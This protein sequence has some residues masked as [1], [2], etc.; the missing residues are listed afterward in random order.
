MADWGQIAGGVGGA[1]LGGLA[2]GPLGAVGGGMLGASLFGK[3]KKTESRPDYP[4]M[5]AENLYKWATDYQKQYPYDPAKPYSGKLSAEMTPIEN[6]SQE[7]LSNYMDMGTPESLTAANKYTTDVL[8]GGYDPRTSP[9]YQAMKKQ[10]LKDAEEG[11][12]AVRHQAATSGMLHSDPRHIQ[13]RKYSENI[14]DQLATLLGQQYENER[15]RMGQA[16]ALA[17]S[18]SESMYSLPLKQIT[19]GST[20][21]AI[22]REVEQQD[23][24]R[25]YDEYLRQVQGASVPYQ[26]LNNIMGQ[27][28]SPYAAQPYTQ[29]QGQSAAIAQTLTS[30]L[31]YLMMLA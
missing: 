8:S 18:L 30:A 3:K 24:G 14:S 22:P 5:S 31:P 28:Y 4:Y 23:L 2:L 7:M 17:P 20:I 6:K 16:A 19:A 11:G 25:Q 12:A 29:G 10:I 9:Y 15:S 1:T 27:S 13:E 26:F 21:G